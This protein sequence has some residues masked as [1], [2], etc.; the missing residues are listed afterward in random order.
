MALRQ[1]EQGGT[2]FFPVTNGKVADKPIEKRTLRPTPES[3]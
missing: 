1:N 2:D 3:A